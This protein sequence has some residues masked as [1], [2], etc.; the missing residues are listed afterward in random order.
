M[1]DSY[2][3]SVRKAENLDVL[4]DAAIDVMVEYVP[5]MAGPLTAAYFDPLGGAI[6]EVGQSDTA[7]W[8]RRTSYGFH[9][10]AGWMDPEDDAEVIDWANEFQNAMKPHSNGGV[11]VNLIADDELDRIPR[12]YGDNFDRIVDVKRQ[13]D[14]KNLFKHNY[15]IA[16]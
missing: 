4:S 13:W 3:R 8:G 16:P 6:S 15:N 10:I 2:G 7:Y 14:P 9:I 11:Y 12:A 5:K 1:L